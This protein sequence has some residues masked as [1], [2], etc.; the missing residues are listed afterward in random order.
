[1]MASVDKNR[2]HCQSAEQHE[3]GE[4]NGN[5][6]KKMKIFARLLNKTHRTKCAL[7]PVISLHYQNGAG[8]GK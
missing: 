1:M 8:T 5:G 3:P 7:T 2:P 6:V 4:E